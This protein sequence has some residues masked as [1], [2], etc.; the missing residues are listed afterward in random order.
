MRDTIECFIIMLAVITVLLAP[1][2]C[3][4]HQNNQ[5]TQLLKE[6][7]SPVEIMCTQE[8]VR[9]KACSDLISRQTE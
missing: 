7:H 5:A 8:I 3:T 6:G 9:S 4:V 1:V 2:A